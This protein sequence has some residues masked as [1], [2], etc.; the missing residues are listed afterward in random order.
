MKYAYLVICSGHSFEVKFKYPFFPFISKS[1]VF[2][3]Q[4]F[5]LHLKNILR[6]FNHYS[7]VSFNYQTTLRLVHISVYQVQKL[8]IWTSHFFKI[9]GTSD[10][11]SCY[12]S[13]SFST[14]FWFHTIDPIFDLLPHNTD[15]PLMTWH[16]M[17]WN[18]W[19]LGI[20]GTY[21]AWHKILKECMYVCNERKRQKELRKRMH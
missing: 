11:R 5:N 18:D 8:Q 15:L 7:N 4:F 19:Q 16:N 13:L 10:G 2:F 17:T 6:P 1:L 12:C 20:T 21:S 14:L 3:P 9:Y